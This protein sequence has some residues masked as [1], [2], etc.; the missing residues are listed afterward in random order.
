MAG[1]VEVLLRAGATH[2]AVILRREHLRA[3]KD[4]NKH[5]CYATIVRGSPKAASTSG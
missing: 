1:V 4:G 5:G 2:T 3:S